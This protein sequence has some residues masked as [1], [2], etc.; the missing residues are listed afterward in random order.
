MYASIH[1]DRAHDGT[2]KQPQHTI[3]NSEQQATAYN[4]VLFYFKVYFA[5]YFLTN[6]HTIFVVLYLSG[7]FRVYGKLPVI[8]LL[9]ILVHVSEPEST[10]DRCHKLS[11]LAVATLP[12]A[13]RFQGGFS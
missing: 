7:T 12:S 10:A 11:L 5:V 4:T 9:P 2:T 13:L 8:Q 6:A 1:L 3:S